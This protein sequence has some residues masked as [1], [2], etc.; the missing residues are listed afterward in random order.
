[1]DNP[2]R[3]RRPRRPRW[4]SRC[5]HVAC[6]AL[7]LAI[8][9]TWLGAAY[10]FPVDAAVVAGMNAPQCAS[11]RALAAGARLAAPMSDSDACLPFYLYRASYTNAADDAHGYRTWVLQQRLGEFWQ[12]IGYMLALWFVALSCV[13]IGAMVV[14]RL[15]RRLRHAQPPHAKHLTHA[16]HD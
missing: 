7:M 3:S 6:V 15:V 10:D 11:V 4:L 8:G 14:G 16:S 1:M 5:F 2:E 9:M 13:A 12:L